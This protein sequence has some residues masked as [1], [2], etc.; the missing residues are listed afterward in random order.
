MA[1]YPDHGVNETSLTVNADNAMYFAK[2]NGRNNIQIFA[3]EMLGSDRSR[4]AVNS[5]APLVAR[6]AEGAQENAQVCAAKS[7]LQIQV[8]EVCMTEV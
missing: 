7:Q 5:T 4:P 8:A 2:Q 3:S 6:Q 1:M